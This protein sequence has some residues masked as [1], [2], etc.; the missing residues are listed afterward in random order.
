[1]QRTI[2]QRGQPLAR[3]GAWICLCA[4][5]VACSP[6]LDWRETR[7]AQTGV[8]LLM[9]CK[10]Q[11]HERQV[12]LAGSTV[13]MSLHA[14]SAGE[15]T[16]ALAF[17]DVGDPQRLGAALQALAQA[18]TGNVNATA[19]RELALAVPGATPHAFSKRAQA[20]GQL[21]DGQTRQ[22]QFAVF[23]HGTQVFQ[24]TA[25]GPTLPADAAQTFMESIRFAP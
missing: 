13:R 1:M 23:A 3:W 15:Q 2:F 16:W 5:L 12:A 8:A 25:L 11:K 20:Q 14:C 7:P 6:A 17:A 4:G 9:P 18:A 10:P 21:A 22:V 24:A 19:T